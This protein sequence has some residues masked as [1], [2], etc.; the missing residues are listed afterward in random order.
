[1]NRISLL[2]AA[3]ALL[4]AP[5]F[6]GGQVNSAPNH[7]N[8]PTSGGA[9]HAPPNAV[10]PGGESPSVSTA[11]STALSVG[12]P[13]GSPNGISPTITPGDGIAK[14]PTVQLN[15]A[16]AVQAGVA[17]GVA[18]DGNANAQATNSNGGG[19]DSDASH[20]PSR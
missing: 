4:A 17:V 16:P 10:S 7:Q 8:A 13:N 2:S 9:K 11:L 15:G 20:P 3:L 6:A 14:K 1:M 5:A 12:G 19:Q 18:I